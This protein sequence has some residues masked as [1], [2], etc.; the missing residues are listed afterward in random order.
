MRRYSYFFL[1]CCF[2]LLLNSCALP[3]ALVWMMSDSQEKSDFAIEESEVEEVSLNEIGMYIETGSDI[4]SYYVYAGEYN[5]IRIALPEEM[6][7]SD[8]VL[9]TTAG[10]IE[11]TENDSTR[12]RLFVKEPNISLEIIALNQKTGAQGFLI[13]ETIEI[14]VPSLGFNDFES[15]EISAE[16]FKKQ[17]QLMVFY[18]EEI[19]SLCKCKG[20]SLIRVPKEGNKVSL[21]N[22]GDDFGTEA[23]NLVSKAEK[24]DIY[25]FEEIMV[26]CNGY[27]AD[28]KS[29]SLVYLIK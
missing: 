7:A 23:R 28:K 29:T 24:G 18:D 19:L 17:G 10:T 12:F 20:F 21:K 14:S 15:G 4:E 16:D 22:N 9:S 11:R 25:I 2:P 8:I 27:S 13:T 3:V 6:Y 26:S 5:S 1:M